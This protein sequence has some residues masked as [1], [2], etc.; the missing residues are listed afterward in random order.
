MDCHG[1][2]LEIVMKISFACFPLLQKW[3]KQ[4]CHCND[5]ADQGLPSLTGFAN[6]KYCF[7]CQYEICCWW[8]NLTTAPW[9]W[10]SAYSAD[11]SGL[12]IILRNSMLAV[13]AQVRNK[14]TIELINVFSAFFA[15]VYKISVFTSGATTITTAVNYFYFAFWALHNDSSWAKKTPVSD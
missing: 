14:K 7:T 9:T 2:L 13:K 3:G 6:S 15:P 11:I 10:C 12:D 1:F 5:T 4:L 8:K